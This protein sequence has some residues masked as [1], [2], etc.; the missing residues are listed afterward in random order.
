MNTNTI[1]IGS[2]IAGMTAALYLNRANIDFIIV[3]ATTPGGQILRTSTI[4]NYPGF[5]EIDGPTLAVNVY[6][7]LS[8]LNVKYYYDNVEEIIKDND[9]Y[10]VKCSNN[11]ISC[12]NIIVATGRSPRKLGIENEEK[13]IG[14]GISFCAICDGSLYKDKNVAVIGGG[15]SA[16][17]ES[18]YLS[19]FCNKV[20]IIV[21]SDTF[22]ADETL[23]DKVK[24]NDKIEI[25]TNRQV[26]SV[27]GS[28]KL[29]SI[30][31]D[32]NQEL[33]IDGMFI[34]IGQEPNT[35]ILKDLNILNNYGYIKV[36]KNMKTDIN[37]IYAC[38][39][40]ID[41]DLYQIIT[42]A[43]EGAIAANQIIKANNIK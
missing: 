7:Q 23:I 37:N 15:N 26:K 20:T 24:N 29:E 35:K 8:S 3:E 30:I 32:N 28:D 6:K 33:E 38:G 1:I 4:E 39:D 16:F 18:L 40:C 27:N 14:K 36:D 5:K 12:K 17:E 25:L 19:N 22:R 10:K 13:L 9:S 42:S 21:R 31:L 34:Y 2:G 41:K 43:S 11:E